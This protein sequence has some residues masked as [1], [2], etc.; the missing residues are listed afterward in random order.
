MMSVFTVFL[1]PF[2]L[3]PKVNT[4]WT[5]GTNIYFASKGQIALN[6]PAALGLFYSLVGAP[7]IVGTRSLLNRFFGEVSY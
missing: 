7:I 3:A 4:T 5:I 2:Y 1:Q 6:A